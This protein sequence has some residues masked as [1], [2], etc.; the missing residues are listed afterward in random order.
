MMDALGVLLPEE[1]LPLANIPGIVPPFLLDPHT[2]L[3]L[4]PQG[5]TA[6]GRSPGGSVA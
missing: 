2:I 4:E 3:A 6:A 1:V 5:G